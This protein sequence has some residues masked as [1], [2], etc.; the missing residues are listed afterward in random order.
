[1]LALVVFFSETDLDAELNMIEHNSAGTVQLAN[2]RYAK[3]RRGQG[4]VYGLDCRGDGS[5]SRAVYAATTAFVLSFAHNL[6]YE[7]K[8]TVINVTALRPGPTET[9]FFHRAGMDD[10]AVGQKRKS[11]SQPDDLAR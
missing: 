1:M 4:F 6:R 5:Y 10:T 8:E 11:E 7:L 9:D 2:P 3:A